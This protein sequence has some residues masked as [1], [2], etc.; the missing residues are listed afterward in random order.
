VQNV[1]VVNKSNHD[2]TSAKKF[3]K[4]VYLSVGKMSRYEPNKMARQFE[5]VLK[6]SSEEDYL[7]MSGLSMMNSIA[8]AIFVQK[9]RRLNL[10]LFKDG[11]YLERNLS[12]KGDGNE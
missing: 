6:G 9:H 12:F 11:R 2:F 10:L 3:G 7:L 8:V 4:L 1:Y 5:D